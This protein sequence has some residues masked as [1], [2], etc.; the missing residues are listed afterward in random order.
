MET[1][2]RLLALWTCRD[3]IWPDAVAKLSAIETDDPFDQPSGRTPAGWAETTHA[4]DRNEYPNGD[5][6]E[7]KNWH[8]KKDPAANA[9]LWAQDTPPLLK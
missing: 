5:K 1:S 2:H 3:P 4:I 6:R 7:M 9:L 8:G